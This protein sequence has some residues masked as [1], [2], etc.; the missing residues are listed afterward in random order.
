MLGKNQL[1]QTI[2]DRTRPVRVT[3]LNRI[4]IDDALA[5]MSVTASCIVTLP[6]CDL[7]YWVK[8]NNASRSDSPNGT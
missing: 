7:S 5:E 8:P 1:A 6:S 4:E 3:L 2:P